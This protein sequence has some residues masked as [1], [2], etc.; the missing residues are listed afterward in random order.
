M[1][2][3]L[4]GIEVYKLYRYN[5][6]NYDRCIITFNKESRLLLLEDGNMEYGHI[7]LRGFN[8]YQLINLKH[9]YILYKAH[10]NV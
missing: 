2:L 3:L 1:H 9:A 5:M 6:L 8:S 10:F 7:N 4:V